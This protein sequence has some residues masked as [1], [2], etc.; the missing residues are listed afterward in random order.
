[1]EDGSWRLAHELVHLRLWRRYGDRVP[2]WI[3]EGLATYLAEQ[4]VPGHRMD[5]PIGM[6]PA[7]VQR[8]TSPDE[9]TPAFYRSA[10][11]MVGVV[12]RRSGS[13]ALVELVEAAVRDKVRWEDFLASRLGASEAEI[14]EFSREVEGGRNV[15]DTR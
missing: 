4:I 5:I 12:E 6:S 11:R 2:L 7:A 9:V 1:M 13:R 3:D 15:S 14:A 8:A 10:A